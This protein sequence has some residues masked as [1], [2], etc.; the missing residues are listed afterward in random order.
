MRQ[1]VGKIGKQR[2]FSQSVNVFGNMIRL[3]NVREGFSRKE[4]QLPERVFRDPLTTGI[5]K[6]K[7]IHRLDFE[8]MLDEYYKVRG[9][10]ENGNP[11][12]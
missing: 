4:D 9:W 10:N 2:D 3:Y 12:S 1:Q 5:A 11:N 6:G 8:K 7:T